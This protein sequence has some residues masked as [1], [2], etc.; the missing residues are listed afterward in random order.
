MSEQTTLLKYL[1]DRRETIGFWL[2]AVLGF[3]A[4]TAANVVPYIQ[5]HGAYGFDGVEISGFPFVFRSFGGFSP[6]YHFSHLALSA[7]IAIV[8]TAGVSAGFLTKRCIGLPRRRRRFAW[9]A[10]PTMSRAVAI[11]PAT[12]AAHRCARGSRVCGG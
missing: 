10:G 12:I 7:D 2:G 6:A 1:T 3:V 9:W 11:H 5:T 8:L 4:A